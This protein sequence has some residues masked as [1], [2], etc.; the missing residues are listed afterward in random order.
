MRCFSMIGLSL[1]ALLVLESHATGQNNRLVA[2]ELSQVDAD[3]YLM[4]EYVGCVAGFGNMGLQVVPLGDGKFSA[5]AYQGGL[6]GNG[7]NRV[8]RVP[9]TGVSENGTLRLSSD[10]FEI[11]V[12][13]VFASVHHAAGGYAGQ[14]RKMLRR[15]RTLGR[16]PPGN[17]LVLFDGLNASQ[18]KNAK[19]RDGL[20]QVGT[21]LIPTF[22]DFEMHLEFML[23]YMPYARSQGRANSGVYLQSRYEVQILDS[24]GLEGK[25]NECGA[26]YRYIPPDQNMVFPPLTW[27]TYDITFR[28]PRFATDGEKISNARI[29]VLHNGV[30]VH[31]HIE[32]ERK[33]GAGKKEGPNPL[34]IKLQDHGNPVQFRNVWIIDRSPTYHSEWVSR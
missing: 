16:R 15:S 8:K 26:L 5:M 20:L 7:W 22:R 27:Q 1:L 11:T 6:P 9:L 4:G 12:Q 32:V 24:F 3:Y 23:P 19:V 28:A 29:T 34:P 30:P 33:T 10:S 2:T 17:A 31:D 13:G 18:L 25:F 14:L 21:E